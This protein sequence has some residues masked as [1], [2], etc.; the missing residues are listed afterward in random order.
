MIRPAVTAAAGQ[1]GD[2]LDNAIRGNVRKCVETIQGLD[3][4]LSTAVRSRALKVV[5]AVYVLKTG[6]VDVLA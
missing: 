2:M 5:G 6:M 4:I 1:A 3:P